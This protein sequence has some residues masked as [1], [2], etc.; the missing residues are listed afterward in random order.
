M[1]DHVVE[2]RVRSDLAQCFFTVIH[3]AVLTHS[4]HAHGKLCQGLHFCRAFTH[5]VE[6]VWHLQVDDMEVSEN[7]EDELPTA[8]LKSN[9]PAQKF[10]W[11]F[12]M[13]ASLISRSC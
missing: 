11:S 6:F 5:M 1:N 12:I 10:F 13:A 7:S 9:T 8:R 4:P 2:I 3:P